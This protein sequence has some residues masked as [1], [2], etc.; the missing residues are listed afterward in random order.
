MLPQSYRVTKSN[1]MELSNFRRCQLFSYSGTSQILCSP[2]VHYRVHNSPPLVPILSQIKPLHI[3][4]VSLMVSFLLA[5]PPYSYVHSSSPQL[6]YMFCRSH[7]PWLNHSNY[8][9]RRTQVMK[10][11]IMQFS[12]TSCHVISLR[13]KYSPQQTIHQHPQSVFLP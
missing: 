2:K 10:L 4:P 13:S 5:F 12:T 8:N 3:P 11:F 1:S 7:P 9:C 6:C